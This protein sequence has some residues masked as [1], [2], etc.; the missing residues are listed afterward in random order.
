LKN[1]SVARPHEQCYALVTMTIPTKFGL[2][3]KVARGK[4]PPRV[5]LYGVLNIFNK[6]FRTGNRRFAFDRI[7][8]EH[9]DV[10]SY[11]TSPD[12]RVKYD[13]ILSTVL[14]CRRGHHAA[15]D[16]GCSVGVL[17][18]RLAQHFEKVVAFDIS[19]EALRL[20]EQD[21]ATLHN[22][23]TKIADVRSF[24]LGV[25]FDVIICA[26]M[27]RYVAEHESDAVCRRIAKHLSKDGVL[28][29]EYSPEFRQWDEYL[30]RHF[31]RLD[32]VRLPKGWG[33]VCIYFRCTR[34]IAGA[35][36]PG[37]SRTP[38]DKRRFRDN[39]PIVYPRRGT[40]TA[41]TTSCGMRSHRH[42]KRRIG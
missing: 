40:K 16:V 30:K 33:Y 31:V 23:E 35:C 5:L 32:E 10:W 13:L 9:G 1:R 12:E 14:R 22:V 42:P 34:K 24:D 17:S 41:S 19:L 6:A 38:H 28:V 36:W 29:V 25:T 37:G 3:S 4:V 2:I 20:A 8:L 7:Y 18:G 11:R 15:L 21:L 39:H 27:L 26:G